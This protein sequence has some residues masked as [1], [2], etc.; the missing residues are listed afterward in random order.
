MV[1]VLLFYKLVLRLYLILNTLYTRYIYAIYTLYIRYIHAIYTLYI[2]YIYAI[3]TAYIRYIL[4]HLLALLY[5]I[6][7]GWI[8]N[9]NTGIHKGRLNRGG[10]FITQRYAACLRDSQRRLL[11]I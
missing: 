8:K 2:R 4:L 3:N 6:A 9:Y 1:F 7:K 10:P 5:P 11:A